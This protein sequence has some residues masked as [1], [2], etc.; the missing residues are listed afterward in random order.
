MIL[1]AG[2]RLARYAIRSARMPDARRTALGK[3]SYCRPEATFS[4]DD[5]NEV[6]VLFVVSARA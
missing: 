1:M 2:T 6:M 3:P 5:H 4:D